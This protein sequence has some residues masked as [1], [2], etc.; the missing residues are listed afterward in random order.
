[1]ER[2]LLPKNHKI[3]INGDASG[4]SRDTRGKQ[5]DYALI[6]KFMANS[7]VRFEIDVP[8]ANPRVRDRH[9]IV[10]G[11]I[12]NA[13]NRRSLFVYKDAPTADEAFRMTALKK[14]GQ[15]VEDDS[16]RFQ[17]IGTAIGYSLC[18]YLRN[19]YTQANQVQALS[20][21]GLKTF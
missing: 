21:F 14:G 11:R 17:H 9:N 5:S 20:R 13:N 8:T 16:K 1:M 4:R 10:N 18:Q 15:Y 12:C 3:I 2:G 19:A 6:E 7:N